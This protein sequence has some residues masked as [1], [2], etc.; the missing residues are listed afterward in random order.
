MREHLDELLEK[1]HQEGMESLSPQE[2]R[3]LETASQKLR[4]SH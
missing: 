1:I 2:R 3:F 4:K